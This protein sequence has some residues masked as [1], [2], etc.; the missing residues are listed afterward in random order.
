MT[1]FVPLFDWLSAYKNIYL[2]IIP[3]SI[4]CFTTPAKL[5]AKLPATKS[6]SLVSKSGTKKYIIFASHIYWVNATNT[7]T[8]VISQVHKKNL[9]SVLLFLSTRYTNTLSQSPPSSSSWSMSISILCCASCTLP[10][11]NG[12]GVPQCNLICNTT[13]HTKWNNIYLHFGA[14]PVNILYQLR[15]KRQDT[16]PN[17]ILKYQ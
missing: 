7:P 12:T 15:V 11:C 10:K 6:F 13:Q 9:S 5:P 4:Y 14:F 17:A 8:T 1:S 3:F 16:Q 2:V